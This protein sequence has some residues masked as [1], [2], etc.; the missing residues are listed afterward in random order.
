MVKRAPQT[1]STPS[2]VI[3]PT[4]S[5]NGG[6]QGDLVIG[7]G[8]FPTLTIGGHL[9]GNNNGVG[10]GASATVGV[11]GQIL[12]TIL[13]GGGAAVGLDGMIIDGGA[14]ATAAEGGMLLGFIPPA[15]AG[16]SAGGDLGLLISN[17][18]HGLVGANGGA[19]ATL[20]G[21]GLVMP[22]STIAAN[23]AAH[24]GAIFNN[25]RSTSSSSSASPTP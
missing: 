17:G 8:I 23:I 12:P 13:A 11:G 1:S 24:F 2:L 9:L 18:L 6:I 7:G 5:G 16:V 10:V 15:N 22:S 19:W 25:A 21:G 20:G 14:S 3:F 4:I